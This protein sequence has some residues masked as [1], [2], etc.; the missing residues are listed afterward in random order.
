[1]FRRLDVSKA[2]KMMELA[3]DRIIEFNNNSGYE[4]T[5][6]LNIRMKQT[7]NIKYPDLQYR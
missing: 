3:K 1:M 4:N 2:L 7:E 6:F 5:D